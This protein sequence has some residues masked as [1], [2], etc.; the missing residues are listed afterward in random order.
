MAEYTFADFR[1]E[2]GLKFDDISSEEYRVYV[3]PDGKEKETVISKPI[4]LNAS[5]SGGHRI[6]D[7]LGIC[8]YV[9][10]GWKH[11]YWKV[12]EGHPHFVK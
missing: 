3:R 5:K 8:H 11:L 2:S 7:T 6:F 4:A 12:K 10:P 1:N 9:P